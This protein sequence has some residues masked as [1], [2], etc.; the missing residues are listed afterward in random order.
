MI[1]RL[2][3]GVG[4]AQNFRD[5]MVFVMNTLAPR[6]KN[7]GP[8]QGRGPARPATSAAMARRAARPGAGMSPRL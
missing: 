2:V 7:L 3:E 8:G 1:P 4:C 5:S 6:V